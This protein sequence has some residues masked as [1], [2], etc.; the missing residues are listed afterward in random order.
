M[1]DNLFQVAQALKI[2]DK[3]IVYCASNLI[4]TFYN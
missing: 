4:D 2:D 3:Q 1:I